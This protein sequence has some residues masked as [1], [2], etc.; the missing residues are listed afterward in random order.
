MSPSGSSPPNFLASMASSIALPEL[1]RLL[2]WVSSAA[3]PF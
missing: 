2:T 1:I 3:V